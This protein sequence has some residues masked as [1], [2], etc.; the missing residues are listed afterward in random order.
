MPL[1]YLYHDAYLAPLMTADR[2]ARAVSD[3]AAL[4]AFPA[5]WVER[6]AVLRAM[7]LTCL[8]SQQSPDDLFGVK[9]GVYRREFDA[10]LPQARAAQAA[11]AA[12]DGNAPSGAA[13]AAY[14]LDI[15]RA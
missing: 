2:E 9:L 14:A 3:V 1:T 13:G 4:G 12:A 7:V 5:A 10:A 15:H 6:L 11:A 8:D